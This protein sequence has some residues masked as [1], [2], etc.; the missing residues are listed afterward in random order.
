MNCPRCGAPLHPKPDDEFVHCSYCQDDMPVPG[1]AER[2][3]VKRARQELDRV[4]KEMKRLRSRQGKDD[5]TAI[6]MQ[7]NQGVIIAAVAGAIALTIFIVFEIEKAKPGPVNATSLSGGT[8]MVSTTQPHE[9]V[10]WDSGNDP[11]AIAQVAGREDF[12][13]AFWKPGKGES[14]S[15]HSV[16]IGIFDGASH[17]ERWSIGPLGKSG[18]AKGATHVGASNG[19]IVI[20]DST[21]NARVHD[22]SSGKELGV[23]TLSD[24][25]RSVCTRGNQA[26]IDVVGDRDMMLDLVN[27]KTTIAA[28]PPWCPDRSSNAPE[29]ASHRGQAQCFAAST[30]PPAVNITVDRVLADGGDAVALGVSDTSTPIAV[31]FDKSTRAIRWRQTLPSSVV[32]NATK[33]ASSMAEIALGTLLAQYELKDSKWRL[34]AFDVKSGE[35]L[36][37]ALVP[38][39]KHGDE[40]RSLVTSSSRAYLSHG[41]WLDIFD[42]KTGSPIGEF[43]R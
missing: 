8:V 36:W 16:Y 26:W 12:V 23:A 17:V 18:A 9:D 11:P 21:G 22:A 30:A 35:R 6:P 37:D 33:T 42:L 39:S 7:K 15:N 40:A 14:R 29:C 10:E 38:G 13:G 24:R 25:A 3:E 43:G 41:D 34:A 32:A 20:T 2:A 31:G 1:A 19:R 5:A 4:R 28:R 27:I